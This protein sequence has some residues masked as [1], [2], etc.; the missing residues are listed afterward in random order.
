LLTKDE[1][2]QLTDPTSIV[3]FMA[4]SNGNVSIPVA[5]SDIGLSHNDRAMPHHK[6]CSLLTELT[7]LAAYHAIDDS[8]L[9]SAPCFWPEAIEAFRS[10]Q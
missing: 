6:Y 5:L 4:C 9:Y 8:S 7:T 3:P 10:Y 2:A 1:T